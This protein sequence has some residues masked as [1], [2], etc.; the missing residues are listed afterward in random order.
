[1]NEPKVAAGVDFYCFTPDNYVLMSDGEIQSGTT[2]ECL[3]FIK[4]HKLK[5]LK[6]YVDDND[7]QACDW[8]NDV[9][10]IPWGFLRQRGFNVIKTTKGKGVD[11]MENR[12]EWHYKNLTKELYEKAIKQLK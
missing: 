5:N 11:W 3:L 12:I 1:M 6:V 9:L 7:L 2:W 4:Q 10:R 8:I